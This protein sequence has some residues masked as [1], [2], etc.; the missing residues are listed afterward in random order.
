MVSLML[1]DITRDA[2]GYLKGSNM[3]VCLRY[4]CL[5]NRLENP[6]ISTAKRFSVVGRFARSHLDVPSFEV[7]LFDN[8]GVS[9]A[10]VDST[11][12]TLMNRMMDIGI[13]NP[14]SCRC[15]HEPLAHLPEVHL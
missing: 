2:M 14:L 13:F 15:D 9:L 6:D 7:E 3:Q 5:L 12:I 10:E 1:S 4:S 8:I 11:W